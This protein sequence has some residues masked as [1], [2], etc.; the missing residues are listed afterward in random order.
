MF[1]PVIN[2]IQ[3]RILDRDF[4]ELQS[5]LLA[6]PLIFTQ[7]LYNIRTGRPFEIS[8]PVGRESHHITIFKAL[9]KVFI[10]ETT[11]LLIHVPPRYSK[12]EILINFISWALAIFADANFLYISYSHSLAKKQTQTI[13]EIINLAVYRKLFDVKISSTSSA[14]DDF[15]TSAGGSVYA[16]GSGGTI[17]GRGAGIKN[18]ERFGGAIIL[19]DVHKPDEVS[20]DTIRNGVI[21]WYYNTMQS[22]LNNGSKTPIILIGQRLHEA[23]LPSKLM[24]SG[25]WDSLIIPALDVVDNALWP[26]MHTKEELLKMKEQEPYVFAAQMQQDPQPAGGGVF[27]KEWFMT[28]EDTPK[29]LAT[30]ITGDTAETEKTYNDATVFSFWGLYKIKQA[31][32]E[33]DIYGLHWIDCIQEWVEPKDLE[34]LFLDFYVSC[35]RYDVKPQFAAIEKKST[36]TILL[37]ILSKMQGL[38]VVDIN[39]TKSSGS[40]TDRFLEIQGIIGNKEVTLPLGRKHTK[41]CIDHCSKITANNS[42]RYDDIADTL[43]DAVKIALIDKTLINLSINQTENHQNNAAKKLADEQRRRQQLRRERKW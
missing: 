32:V 31:G 27:K 13:R 9:F 35:M 25:D 26:S 18:C 2:N 4:R 33:L 8:N 7:T 21:D 10:G 22:R 14:K 15:E 42:H 39:R 24:E 3:E 40:K 19:D 29:I 6:S 16:A 41:M 20:S 23:D 36:G 30:F 5:D 1:N 11:R 34:T 12:T 37:S 17:C 38:R 28:L 43:Y